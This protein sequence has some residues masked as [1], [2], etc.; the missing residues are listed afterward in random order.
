MATLDFTATN[1]PRGLK[2][3]LSLTPDVPYTMENLSNSERV[4]V[5]EAA[6]APTRGER[7]HV[8]KPGDVRTAIVK[9]NEDLWCWT[10]RNSQEAACVLTPEK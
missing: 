3:V 6:T 9:E 8:L 7:G 4:R 5:R 10:L 2:A 1:T